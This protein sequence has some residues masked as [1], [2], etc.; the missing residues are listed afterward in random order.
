MPGVHRQTADEMLRWDISCDFGETEVSH[1]RI[2]LST[3]SRSLLHFGKIKSTDSLSIHEYHSLPKPSPLAT[4]WLS[5]RYSAQEHL[6]LPMNSHQND[7]IV[8]CTGAKRITGSSLI[9]SLWSG[10]GEIRRVELSG[11]PISSVVVKHVCP[12]AEPNQPRGWNTRQSH[13]R[14]L[15]SYLVESNW[16]R[17]WSDRLPRT[18]RVAKCY[19]AESTRNEHLFVL[20]DLDAEGF[21]KRYGGTD[22]DQVLSGLR[23]LAE[24][25][26]GWMRERPAG[27][28]PTG[29]YWHLATRPD[30]LAEMQPE[31]PLR[32]HAD[33]IDRRLSGC[34][35][36]TV[37]HG[38]AKV[39]N[40]CYSGSNGAVA[41]V[42]FQYVGGGC[43]MKDV[44]Y[45][46]GSCLSEEEC[47]LHADAMLEEYF[48]ALRTSIDRS[49]RNFDL[50]A[51]ES[52][53]RSMYPLAWADFNRFLLGWYP[54]HHKLH[55]YSRRMT[56]EALGMLKR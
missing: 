4:F 43:G 37:V 34:E 26:G 28:W 7:L 12:P 10:Y 8:R 23:W 2:T 1:G 53:W 33:A 17:E 3:K 47:E 27:L 48:D 11:G 42:D 32:V 55:G 20:E 29:T 15:Q 30:E 56:E 25:H 38:D 21:G 50:A 19:L 46:L 35:Y 18:C 39:A 9:Q 45:F 40:F 49:E 24:F 41:A 16:Y 5:Q 6:P 44:A 54:R 13:R 52:E 51:I 36:L 22:L 31:E 14:K